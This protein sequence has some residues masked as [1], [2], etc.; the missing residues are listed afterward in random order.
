MGELVPRDKIKREMNN[1]PRN[2]MNT[3]LGKKKMASKE[4]TPIRKLR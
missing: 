2:M 4:N 3:F 1:T